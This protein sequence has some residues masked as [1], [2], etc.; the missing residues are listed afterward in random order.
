MQRMAALRH[1]ACT[2]HPHTVDGRGAVAGKHMGRQ[3]GGA[4]QATQ[5]HMLG[6]EH[7][8]IRRLPHRDARCSTGPPA[9]RCLR[10]ALHRLQSHSRDPDLLLM[11]GRLARAQQLWGKAQSYFEASLSIAPTLTAH[12]ELAQLLQ[13][14][15]RPDEARQHVEASVALALAA[16]AT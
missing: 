13:S 16:A 4:G 9:A 10:P 1:T 3:H 6:I 14:L 8:P 2:A 15:D 7:H 11:L 5:G 12:A